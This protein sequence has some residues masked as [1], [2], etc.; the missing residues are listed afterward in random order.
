MAKKNKRHYLGIEINPDY[1]KMA[2]NRIIDECSQET[3]IIV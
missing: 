2:E 1:V 3:F